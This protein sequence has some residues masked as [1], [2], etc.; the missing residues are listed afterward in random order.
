MHTIYRSGTVV[1]EKAPSITAKAKEIIKYEGGIEALHERFGDYY[2]SGFA[3]GGDTVAMASAQSEDSSFYRKLK[4]LLQVQFLIVTFYSTVTDES[5]ASS[6]T[7]HQE[8]L[9]GYD[10]LSKKF[11]LASARNE[12]MPR[13]ALADA[14]DLARLAHSLGSRVDEK[15]VE[16][17]LFENE[18]LTEEVCERLFRSGLVVELI[19][20]PVAQLRDVLMWRTNTDIIEYV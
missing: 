12:Q 8:S 16:A 10:S 11:V 17:R 18:P 4:I 3:L 5:E 7:D 15:M 13:E 14:K 2:V 9:T 19:L 6:F 20:L 1:L